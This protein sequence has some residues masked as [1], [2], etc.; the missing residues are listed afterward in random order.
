MAKAKTR[1]EEKGPSISSLVSVL[2]KDCENYRDELSKDRMKA[3]EYFDGVMKDTPADPNRSKV[4][5]R[6][7]RSAIKKAKPS[8]VRTILGNDKVVEYQPVN[9]GDEAGAEQATDY[10]NYIVLPESGGEDAIED[11]ADDALKLRNGIIRVWSEKKRVVNVSQHSGLDEASLVQLVADDSVTIIGKSESM[12]QIDPGQGQPPVMEKVYDIK[13]RRVTESRVTRMAAVSPEDFLIHPD[14]MDIPTSPCT[15]IHTKERRSELVARGY[16]RALIEKLPP[17]G[18]DKDKDAEEDTRRRAPF[19]EMDTLNKA[20]QEV[21]YYELYVWLDTDDDG[22]AELRR[23]CYAGSIKDEYLLENEET[24]LVPFADLV[25]ERRPH[26]REGNA[27]SDDAMD[28]QQIKTVLIRQT[29]DN[30]YWQ[31]NMQPVVQEGVVQNPEAVLNPKFGQPIRV[32]QGVDA[33]TAVQYNQVPFVAQQSFGML[34]YLDQELTDR[35]GISDAS[36]GLAPDAL[37]NVTAKASAMM[38]QA[39]IGQ[40]EQMVRTFARGL[41]RVFKLL[42]QTIIKHQDKPRTVRLRGEWVE[43]DPRQWNAD[44]DCTVNTGLGAGT[45]ERDMMMMQMIGQQQEKLLAAYGPTNNPYVTADNIWNSISK[46]VEATG[47]RTPQLYFSKPTPDQIEKMNQDAANKPNPEM[48]K[49]KAQQAADAA[50]AQADMQAQQAKAQMDFQ[51][52]QQKDAND[53]QLEMKK[54][55]KEGELKKYQID[56]EIQMKQKQNMAQ[57]MMQEPISDTR[58]G[59]MAG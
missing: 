9:D 25:T 55:E 12:Q 39:G 41:K 42:L 24:D 50:K 6:D 30:I 43:F 59:G 19:D 49:I 21:D 46:G 7:V 54:I 44:M 51:L 1:A 16:D 48:E 36:S 53:F 31:N 10:I 26:Q 15:G 18:S 14:A 11:A 52:Q 4:V 28:I 8:I 56:Q 33:R 34:S 37:Q 45:R 57:L 17:A 20:L 2:V 32:Q 38:E 3:N 27:V 5:S 35:T 40:T 23:L 47:L 13:I 22:I 29:L 58:I